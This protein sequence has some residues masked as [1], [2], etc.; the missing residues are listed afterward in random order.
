[1]GETCRTLKTSGQSDHRWRAEPSGL[2]LDQAR[3]MTDLERDTVRLTKA[4]AELA[5]AS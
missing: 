4:I 5:R 3:R 1:L 2:Q